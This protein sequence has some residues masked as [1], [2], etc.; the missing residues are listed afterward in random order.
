MPKFH[1]PVPVME[2]TALPPAK[3]PPGIDAKVIPS[4][5]ASN[6]KVAENVPVT[7]IEAEVVDT[8]GLLNRFNAM[9]A[10]VVAQVEPVAVILPV[11]LNWAKQGVQ[12]MR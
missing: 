9:Q 1:V 5:L 11:E 10:F 6:C 12:R 2:V 8:V 3:G 4:V 7:T